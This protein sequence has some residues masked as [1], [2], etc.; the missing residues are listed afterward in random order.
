MDFDPIDARLTATTDEFDDLVRSLAEGSVPDH[1][2]A[3]QI[4]TM[5]ELVIDPLR[6]IAVERLDEGDARPLHVGFDQSG[7]VTITSCPGAGTVTV[8]ASHLT[9]LPTL[10]Q[11]SVRIHPGLD[12]S[13]DRADISLAADELHAA[14][15]DLTGPAGPTSTWRAHASWRGSTVDSEVRIVATTDHGLWELHRPG[16]GARVTLQPRSV[17]EV[18][19]RLGDV[20]TGRA[21]RCAG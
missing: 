5:V 20:V 17:A 11:Q 1:E 15:A 21:N 13:S 19:A 2:H 10:L 14:L 7:R 4:S 6:S 8:V 9:L 18:A 12:V 16:D 3:A